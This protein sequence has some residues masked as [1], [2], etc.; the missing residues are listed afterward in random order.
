MAFSCTRS[1]ARDDIY[2][3]ISLEKQIDKSS[4]DTIELNNLNLTDE[5]I[6]III[7]KIIKKNQC[8][9][10]SLTNNKI[11]SNG[12]RM[13]VQSFKINQKLT[14]L[15]LSSNPIGDEGIQFI[16]DFIKLTK[17][18]YHLSLSDTQITD[19]GMKLLMNTL[20]TNSTT[21]R[22]LDLRSNILITDLSID[23]IS[24]MVEHNQTLS[25]CRLDNCGLSQSG[26][27]QLKEIKS[28]KW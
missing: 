13:I 19:Q 6:Q 23:Y 15:T 27:D 16:C 22:C 26:K 21:L 28:I 7:K 8:Q 25:T 1:K 18:L 20:T 4:K 14:H 5:D 9:S 10:L 11:T 24:K 3:N 2:Q 12:I 17:N